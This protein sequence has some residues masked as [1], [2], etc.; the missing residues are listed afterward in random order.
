CEALFARSDCLTSHLKKQVNGKA[1]KCGQC[2]YASDTRDH[3][4]KHEKTHVAMAD[5]EL[6]V[7]ACG[8]KYLSKDTLRE[9]QKNAGH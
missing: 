8:K 6:F 2:D 3:L 9:H 1:F 4:V 5:C 7:C